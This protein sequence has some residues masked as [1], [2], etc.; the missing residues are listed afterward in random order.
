M[1]FWESW[2]KKVD[3][4]NT[5]KLWDKLPEK[6]RQAVLQDLTHRP[7][8]EDKQY[9][10]SPAKYLRGERW[11]DE[12]SSGCQKETSIYVRANV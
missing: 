3:R 5:E 4:R 7:W 10:M 1:T 9:I 8:S 12:E 2:P 11:K 6:D